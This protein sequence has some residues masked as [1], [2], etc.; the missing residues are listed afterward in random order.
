MP[1]RRLVA[2]AI[3]TVVVATCSVGATPTLDPAGPSASASG[4]PTPA[5]VAS[6]STSA[7]VLP[8]DS[9]MADAVAR[10]LAPYGG[11]D[12]IET[13]YDWSAVGE[14]IDLVIPPNGEIVEID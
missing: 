14:P 9:A 7:S 13:W 4:A 2:G 11:P 10:V 1:L 5:S 6:P 3:A 12:R 8:P